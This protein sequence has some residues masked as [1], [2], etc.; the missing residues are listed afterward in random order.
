MALLWEG[1]LCPLCEK[2]IDLNV[3]NYI[4]FPCVGLNNPRYSSLDDS[5]VHRDCLNTW[6]KRDH[7]VTLFNRAL[8]GCPNPLPMRLLV[9]ESGE[10]FW[11]D[12]VRAE[13]DAAAD[14]GNRS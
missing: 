7:F 2:V 6:R 1:M 10:V 8:T 5:A 12:E 4:A 14:R 13:Q 11:D 9:S 3:E